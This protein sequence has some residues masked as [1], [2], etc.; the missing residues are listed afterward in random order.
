[1]S[2]T[3]RPQRQPELPH[4]PEKA[5]GRTLRIRLSGHHPQK[6]L[7]VGEEPGQERQ[8]KQVPKSCGVEGILLRH[9]KKLPGFLRGLGAEGCGRGVV[10]Q[11]EKLVLVVKTQGD[12]G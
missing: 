12:G 10:L 9:V 6:R 3:P 11:P 7:G 4:M 2:P 1:M 8:A 5:A